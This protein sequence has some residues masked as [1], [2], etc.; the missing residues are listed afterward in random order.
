MEKAINLAA[1][2][3]KPSA[4][5]GWK[6]KADAESAKSEEEAQK[7]FEKRLNLKRETETKRHT[8]LGRGSGNMR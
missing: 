8:S 5:P 6:L 3:G 2:N 7:S 4:W 1:Q